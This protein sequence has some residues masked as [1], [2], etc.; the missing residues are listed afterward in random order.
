[1]GEQIGEG[2][3]GLVF[4]CLDVWNNN[5]AAK[6]LKPLGSYDKVKASAL[7]ELQKLLLL[8][9][10]TL[11]HEQG[12]P[13]KVA[14]AQLG[15]SRMTTTLEVYTHASTSAQRQAVNQLESQLFPSVPKFAEV[16]QRPN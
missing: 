9:H 12:T 1:M 8:R 5:L 10:G 11:L 3:F 14:Q 6:V 13:L 15:H 4:G 2:H 7:A 16:G